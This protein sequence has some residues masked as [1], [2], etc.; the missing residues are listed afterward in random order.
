VKI[1]FGLLAGVVGSLAAS[2]AGCG[3]EDEKSCATWV[4][5]LKS[6][7]AMDRSLDRIAELKCAEALP[8]MKDLFVQGQLQDR[9]LQTTKQLGKGDDPATVEI[10]R[11]ALKTNKLAN[12]AAGMAQDWKVA[13]VLPELTA[14]MT[15]PNLVSLREAAF[16]A[17]LA[18]SPDPKTLEDM[19]IGVASADPNTQSA[20]IFELA[21]RE[22]GNMGSVKALPVTLK[23]AYFKNNKGEEVFKAARR[24]LAQIAD[25]GLTPALVEVAAGKHKE[26]DDFTRALNVAD[27]QG[28]LG[29]KSV[30][31]LN[32][33]LE[34]AVVQALLEH[35]GRN[36]VPPQTLS[37]AAKPAWL[38]EQRNRLQM[39]LFALGH[40]ANDAAIPALLKVATDAS[41]DFHNQRS[42]ALLALALIGS[43]AAQDAM[44][45]V[46]QA[47][48]E[49]M[50][51]A[52]FL[53]HVARGVDDRRLKQLDALLGAGSAKGIKALGQS[54]EFTDAL[55][56]EA[57]VGFMAVLRACK[58]D[59][60]CVLE[61][62][63][64]ENQ[65]EQ[66]KAIHLLA[67]G[68]FGDG[69]DIREAL[70]ATFKRATPKDV[71]KRRFS[72]IGLT[73]LGKKADGERL[74]SLSEGLPA[75]DVYWKEE[76]FAFGKA[77]SRR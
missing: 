9:I 60:A 15:D 10:L 20:A 49:P 14:I 51:Q 39:T 77:M 73:R 22:L 71:D 12:M 69:D 36:L 23:L 54:S 57:F 56:D 66:V 1:R 30:Q 3:S 52:F 24:A 50:I 41:A 4:E 74:V 6:A 11:A 7:G 19:L 31:L 53:Q 16:P 37:D 21:V 70:F 64:S 18:L 26:V 59:K 63:K 29:A 8:A 42:K 76:L 34:P 17:L 61:K 25:P 58:D 43:E 67:S 55:K 32:D 47:E 72:L 44:F 48:P 45:Q 5:R 33:R 38:A 35:L 75:E 2:A 13:G 62:L 68:R 27:W 46:I 28:V 40:T 65:H